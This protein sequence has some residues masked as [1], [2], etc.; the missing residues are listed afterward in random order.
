MAFFLK[1]ASP[2]VTPVVSPERSSGS[3]RDTVSPLSRKKERKFKRG[4]RPL[5]LRVRKLS[6]TDEPGFEDPGTPLSLSRFQ[7]TTYTTRYN[8]EM[9]EMTADGDIPNIDGARTGSKV[10]G[11]SDREKKRSTNYTS[12]KIR[13]R[14]PKSRSRQ[15]WEKSQTNYRTSY[16]TRVANDT[17]KKACWYTTVHIWSTTGEMPSPSLSPVRKLQSIEKLKASKMSPRKFSL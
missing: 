5:P 11:R 17:G 4:A 9:P 7:Y 15:L 14:S 8:W 1:S 10:S 3:K 12:F 6:E 13:P 16:R 2:P